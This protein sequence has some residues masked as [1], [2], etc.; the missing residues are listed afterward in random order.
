MKNQELRASLIKSGI[1]LIL[2]VFFIYSFA[3]SDSGGITGTIGSLFSGILFIVGLMIAV[4]VSV[5]FIFG[6]YF[7][8]IYMYDQDTCKTTY[9]EFRTKLSD[10][11]QSLCGQ[12]HSTCS[13]TGVSVPQDNEDTLAPL[14]NNQDKLGSQ[15]TALQNSV[16]SLENSLTTISTSVVAAAQE[17]AT[18][19]EKTN[20][21]EEALESKANTDS[22]SDATK[23]L[24]SD[25]TSAQN[26]IKPLADKIEDLESTLSSLKSE[27]DD[28]SGELQKT[29]DF[30]ISAL[31]DELS[32]MNTAIKKL[33]DQP[34][35]VSNTQ[36]AQT[37]DSDAHRILSYFEKKADE[38][39]FISLVSEA[40]KKGMTYAQVG[41]FLNDSLSDDASDV[42]ADHPSL[43]KDYIRICR[44]NT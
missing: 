17:L 19:D 44:Q 35:V 29:V 2:F 25:I 12:C 3:V 14:K 4:S 7:G 33:S 30:A 18:L 28:S 38:E 5:L 13:S 31:K 1:I 21:I 27:E 22:I 8:V 9:A 26:A 34:S 36:E 16:T 37:E 32:T 20:S 6:I 23:S 42:I 10:L 39:N 41:E 24:S 15:L 43:T 40:V 11:S